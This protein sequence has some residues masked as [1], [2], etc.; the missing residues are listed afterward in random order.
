MK[1][2]AIGWVETSVQIYRC[3][4][5]NNPEERMSLLRRD[6]SLQRRDVMLFLYAYIFKTVACLQV[7]R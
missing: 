2:G 4:L 3:T 1:M 5:R 6:G 7:S